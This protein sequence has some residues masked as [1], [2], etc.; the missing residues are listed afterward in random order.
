MLLKTTKKANQEQNA[1]KS[2]ALI[3]KLKEEVLQE[4]KNSV[5]FI[6]PN[7]DGYVDNKLF[8]TSDSH[9]KM[10]AERMEYDFL[11]LSVREFYEAYI[12]PEQII[13]SEFSGEESQEILKWVQNAPFI[14]MKNKESNQNH[15]LVRDI[16]EFLE[17]NNIN[18][19]KILFSDIKIA[20]S[21]L[22]KIFYKNSV[23]S[24]NSEEYLDDGEKML[25]KILNTA[26]SRDAS[27]IYISLASNTLSIRFRIDEQTEVID[28][29]SSKEASIL[30]NA[31][32]VKASKEPT[33]IGY[34]SKI[35]IDSNDYRV[36]FFETHGGQG[37][38]ATFRNYVIKD[39]EF[40]RIYN[41][42]YELHAQ[43]VLKSIFSNQNGVA[44]FTGAT[45]T[46]KT[47]AQYAMMR[48]LLANGLEC[49]SVENPIEMTIRVN[50]GTENEPNY[51]YVDQIDLT[52]TENAK[53]E[54][55]KQTL[56]K[57]I[58]AFLRA[59][60]DVIMV[61]EIRDAEEASMVVTAST[62]GHLVT[63][64]LHTNSVAETYMRLGEI[65]VDESTFKAVIRGIVTQRLAPR[66]CDNC[67][68]L[69]EEGEMEAKYFKT[70]A[71]EQALD[72]SE[73]VEVYEFPKTI[74]FQHYE[75][76]PDGCEAC[77]NKGYKGKVPLPE[78]AEFPLYRNFDMQNPKTYQNYIPISQSAI[79]NYHMGLISKKHATQAS[80]GKRF[81]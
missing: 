17:I 28:R 75:H 22:D 59:K 78:I 77:K 52:A 32:A 46:G 48:E 51:A 65:G 26:N 64:T 11:G 69:V 23:L 5:V 42:G 4:L 41:I 33:A 56:I 66:L 71:N 29:L 39:Q 80:M 47:I 25:K 24:L 37:W 31:I 14:I 13:K 30:R 20:N 67:K 54:E 3:Y 15:L 1:N 2:K 36:N 21:S 53:E 8:L 58:K 18:M 44:L 12:E 9:M 63:A 16:F 74:K 35:N 10:L 55:H 72:V 68:I 62:T 60:P 61:G 76:N 57:S 45:G 50:K 73:F 81:T 27:D 6:N 79:N 34:D 38:R 7:T 70:E 40:D 43:F 19:L 49:V